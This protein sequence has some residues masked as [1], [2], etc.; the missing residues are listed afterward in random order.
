MNDFKTFYEQ[1]INYIF[2]HRGK[3][4]IDTYH[5]TDRAKERNQLTDENVK[6]MFTRMV[7]KF[8]LDKYPR[9]HYLVFSKSLDQAVVVSYEPDTYKRSPDNHFIIIT[10]LPRGRSNPKPGTTK[11]IVEKYDDNVKFSEAFIEY[12]KP[13]M[14]LITEEA[15]YD[16]VKKDLK[17]DG[18]DVQ[19]ILCNNKIWDM[20][21]E[22][23][24]IDWYE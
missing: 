6:T 15:K 12:M 19:M 18:F 22:L 11:V 5:A 17:I 3:A 8:L 20:V 10:F 9:G 4:I 13:Y 24:E 16:Y 21:P 7:D 2:N 14:T 23:V 1:T